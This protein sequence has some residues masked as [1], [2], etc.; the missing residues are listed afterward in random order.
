MNPL[1]YKAV[2]TFAQVDSV[3]S[4]Y[5]MRDKTV[6][7]YFSFV[8]S[9]VG[10]GLSSKEATLFGDFSRVHIA[11]FGGLGILFDPYT[12]A[13]TGL[14]RMVITSLYGAAATQASSAFAYIHQN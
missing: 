2:K 11:Q 13:A 12:N 14:P 1:A 9:N 6:N 5:D 3:S 8:S 10:N 4:M 7:G